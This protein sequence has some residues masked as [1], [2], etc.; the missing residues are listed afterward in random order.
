VAAALDTRRS[1]A[2]LVGLVV[3]HLGL[4]AHQVDAGGGVSLLQRLL[5][6]V[7]SPFQAAGAAS[8]RGVGDAWR[9]YL[10]LR[11]VREKGRVLEEQVRVLETRLQEREHLAGEALRLQ[12][13]LDLR[14]SL[15]VEA[16]AAEVITRDGLPWSRTLTINKGRSQ[17][18]ALDCPVI[19]SAGVVGRVI[20]LGPSAARVQLL[21]DRDSGA[22]VAIDRTRVS[23]VVSGQVGVAESA[24]GDLLMKYVP[25][26]ADVQDGDLVITSGLDRI[27]PKGLV[28]GSVSRVASGRGLFK[29]ILVTPSVRVEQLELLLVLKPAGERTLKFDEAVR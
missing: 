12:G 23:G 19:S 20:A 28:V 10:D 21:Q 1:R 11:G 27:Y 15:T 6:S 13:L 22:G 2:L 24:S 7:F 26:S 8:I 14:S 5:L 25:D 18:V 16:I 4:I 29:E 3:L 17:G 9:A